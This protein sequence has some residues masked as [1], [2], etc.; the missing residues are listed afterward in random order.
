MIPW[1]KRT[2][3][4]ANLL[5]PS[6]CAILLY[7]AT[8]EYQKKAKNNSMPF[9]LLYLVLPII[10]HKS[11]RNRVNSRTNMVIWLQRNPDV[12]VGF[13]DRTKNLIGFTNEAIEFLLFQ[14]N[15][16]IINGGLSIIKTVSKSKI[17][18]YAAN[19]QEISECIQKAENVGRWFCNMHAVENT[20]TAW[21][22]KP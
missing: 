22:V 12:L 9:P 4:I 21:G 11:T 2:P 20:Y 14:G 17:V 15:C 16:E 10:L 7:S 13:A 8:F 1:S 18:Q 6:F 3:E 19:D 5:N